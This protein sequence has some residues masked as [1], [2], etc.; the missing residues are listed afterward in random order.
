MLIIYIVIHNIVVHGEWFA[1]IVGVIIIICIAL[2][3]KIMLGCVAEVNVYNSTFEKSISFT[4]IPS[5]LGNLYR[6][7][8]QYLCPLWINSHRSRVHTRHRIIIDS[9]DFVDFDD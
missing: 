4:S 3:D 1:F 5:V 6:E 7:I 2:K 8:H 9:M